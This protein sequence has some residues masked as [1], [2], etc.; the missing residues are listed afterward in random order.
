MHIDAYSFGA[1]TVDARVYRADV[2]IFPDKVLD[3]W[4]RKE[5]H[6]LSLDDLAAVIAFQP[7]L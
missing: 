5:D 3:H 2:I 7:T 4:W 6:S 1:M